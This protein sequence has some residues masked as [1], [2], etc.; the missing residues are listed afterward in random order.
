LQRL[1]KTLILLARLSP[2]FLVESYVRIACGISWGIVS[3][4]GLV[5]FMQGWIDGISWLDLIKV[6]FFGR[7]L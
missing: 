6:V 2:E 7:V 1:L 4:I 3:Y 5:G